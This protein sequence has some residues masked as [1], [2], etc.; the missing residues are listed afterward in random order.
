M[1]VRFLVLAD[2]IACL[3]PEKPRDITFN[4]QSLCAFKDSWYRE[5]G[6]YITST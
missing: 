5:W 3:R 4:R 2:F 6:L 1:Q